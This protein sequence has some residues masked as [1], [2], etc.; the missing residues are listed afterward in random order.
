MH[1]DSFEN[2]VVHIL[3]LFT[4]VECTIMVIIITGWIED[5][6]SFY[7]S[8]SHKNNIIVNDIPEKAEF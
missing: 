3:L 8:K 7:R 6:V 1:V 4:L 5:L 2:P